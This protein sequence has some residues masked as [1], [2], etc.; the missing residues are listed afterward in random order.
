MLSA[1]GGRL[2]KIVCG[3]AALNPE[4]AESFS[5]FGIDIFEG[6]GITECS[7]LIAVSPYFDNRPGSVGP[8]CPCCEVRIAATL[9]KEICK[10]NKEKAKACN[11]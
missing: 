10:N 7:P 1:F 6:Y 8:A 3:G 11:E 2:E 5:E 4:V 9:A